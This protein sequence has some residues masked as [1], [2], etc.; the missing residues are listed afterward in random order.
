MKRKHYKGYRSYGYLEPGDRLP[1]FKLAREIGRV[2][3]YDVGVTPEQEAARP[4]PAPAT[5]WSSPSTTTPSSCPRT[6]TRSSSTAAPGRDWTGYEGLAAR[7]ST[8]SSTLSWTAPPS[9]TSKAGWKWDD[10]I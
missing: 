5:T 9:I 1:A 7:A 10:I 4:A 8:P 6:P 3:A 2:P